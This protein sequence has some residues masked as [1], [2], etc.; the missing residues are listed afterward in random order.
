MVVLT[1]GSRYRPL[2]KIITVHTKCDQEKCKAEAKEKKIKDRCLRE[3]LSS[4]QNGALTSHYP[5][6]A[7]ASTNTTNEM[8]ELI[9]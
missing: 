5:V 4:S 9:N 2:G 6:M 1:Q 8:V 7:K 3:D